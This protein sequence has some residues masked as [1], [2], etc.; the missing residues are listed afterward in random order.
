MH[1]ANIKKKKLST[2]CVHQ[3]ATSASVLQYLSNKIK[4]N[5]DHQGYDALL[6]GD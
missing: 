6:T 2:L 4:V 1:G 3:T 5:I